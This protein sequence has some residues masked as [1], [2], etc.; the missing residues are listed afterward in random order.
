MRR[1]RLRGYLFVPSGSEHWT[2]EK[3]AFSMDPCTEERSHV[4]EYTVSLAALNLRVSWP[5]MPRH[6]LS[7]RFFQWSRRP[8]DSPPIFSMES[9]IPYKST[10][11]DFFQG[12]VVPH[13]SASADFFTRRPTSSR[14]DSGRCFQWNR[15]HPTTRRFFPWSRRPHTTPRKPMFSA[16]WEPGGIRERR[17]TAITGCWRSDVFLGCGA[18]GFLSRGEAEQRDRRFKIQ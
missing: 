2:P 3:P 18:S 5:G 9:G 16:K 15:T 10:P 17:S 6:E 8:L 1:E 13:D 11:T 12:V 7:S 14:L 4:E